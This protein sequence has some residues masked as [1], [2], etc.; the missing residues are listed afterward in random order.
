MQKPEKSLPFYDY[1]THCIFDR[2]NYRFVAYYVVSINVIF[3]GRLKILKAVQ[4]TQFVY[5]STVVYS[6]LS[7]TDSNV[8]QIK[9][10]SRISHFTI[11]KKKK[12]NTE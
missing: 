8:A 10:Q 12:K 2:F 3:R 11:K 6:H 5:C 4:L 9:I 7:V 1:G